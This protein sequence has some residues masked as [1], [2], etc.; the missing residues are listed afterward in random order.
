TSMRTL[1]FSLFAC[2]FVASA[3]RFPAAADDCDRNDVILIQ[4]LPG[5]E[6]KGQSDSVAFNYESR[7]EKFS[8]TAHRYIWCIEN[9]D[10][11]P[12]RFLWGTKGVEDLYFDSVIIPAQMKPVI[13][14]DT[15]G[16]DRD[17][18]ILKHQTLSAPSNPNT[19]NPSSPTNWHTISPQ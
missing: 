15:S 7:E 1:I 14:T 8:S 19:Q 4:N 12:A 16:G 5:F 10:S 2:V 13:R 9:K 11:V 18:R 6:P 3:S 17:L